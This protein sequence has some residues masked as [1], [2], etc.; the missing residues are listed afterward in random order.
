MV[1]PNLDHYAWV[2]QVRQSLQHGS[3]PERFD[4]GERDLFS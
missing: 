1:L 3:W 4:Y 2:G